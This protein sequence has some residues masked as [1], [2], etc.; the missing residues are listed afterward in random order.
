MV[1][2]ADLPLQPLV[3]SGN[4]ENDIQ[5]TLLLLKGRSVLAIEGGCLDPALNRL[6]D[7]GIHIKTLS[8]AINLNELIPAVMNNEA[9]CTLIDVPD[10]LVGI[11]KW[12]GKI[13]VLGPLSMNQQMGVGFAKSS[14]KLRDEF[15]IFFLECVEKGIYE[16]LLEKYYPSIFAYYPSFLKGLKKISIQK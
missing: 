12:P 3:P 13:K 11:Q 14:V 6:Q 9:D 16:Q 4:L 5:S 7:S 10:A 8:A 15:N 1:A 2:R